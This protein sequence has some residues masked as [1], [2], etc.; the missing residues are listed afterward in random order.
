M[1]GTENAPQDWKFSELI[2]NL[3]ETQVPIIV[4]QGPENSSFLLTPTSVEENNEIKQVVARKFS[5][6]K[7][8]ETLPFETLPPE[9]LS[10]AAS[11][12]AD[13]LS[14][15][16]YTLDP[17]L[18]ITLDE[19]IEGEK[20]TAQDQEA[21]ELSARDAR[22]VSQAKNELEETPAEDIVRKILQTP[23]IGVA[24]RES[25][26]EDGLV[27][28]DRRSKLMEAFDS[29]GE[30]AATDLHEAM[31]ER[32]AKRDETFTK[33]VERI[34]NEQANKGNDGPTR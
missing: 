13:T 32:A 6:G 11:M 9:A 20:A 34:R 10:V 27:A 19:A 8:G 26:K 25:E 29:K 1:S 3:G 2:G 5:E 23:P 22:T 17:W 7:A 18:K 16:G 14:K 12:L 24:R 33:A 31:E 28:E 21:S 4:A 15:N 30:E